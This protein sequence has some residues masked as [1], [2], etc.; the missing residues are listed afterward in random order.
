VPSSCVGPRVNRSMATVSRSCRTMNV[1]LSARS[2]SRETGGV[3]KDEAD[4]TPAAH[5]NAI[6]LRSA[7]I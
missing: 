4:G 3:N 1:P 5:P 7:A 6:P 2:L